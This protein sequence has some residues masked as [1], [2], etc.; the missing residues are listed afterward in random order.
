MA[1]VAQAMNIKPADP[2]FCFN[3]VLRGRLILWPPHQQVRWS[4]FK[5]QSSVSQMARKL[6]KH[7]REKKK[8]HIL[9]KIILSDFSFHSFKLI[10]KF[11]QSTSSLFC[12]TLTAF[13]QC[14]QLF[15]V[16]WSQS[17][18]TYNFVTSA[19]I[20]IIHHY[21][22]YRI[23]YCCCVNLFTFLQPWSIVSLIWPLLI[24][25]YKSFSVSH[26]IKACSFARLNSWWP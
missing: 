21:Y 12:L 14:V 13:Q 1:E 16:K 9:S 10:L 15:S 23:I 3:G 8:L 19:S 11:L 24:L 7:K 6:L 22:I 4:H 17:A 20:I 25:L 18:S 26:L 2:G 5:G